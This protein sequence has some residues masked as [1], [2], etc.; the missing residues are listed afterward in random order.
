MY[1][2]ELTQP[3]KLTVDSVLIRVDSTSQAY[4]AYHDAKRIFKKA[5]M[6]LR[7]WN[8][9]S[10]EFLDQILES[11]CVCGDISKVF[12][13]GWNRVSDD[14]IFVSGINNIMPC[15]VITRHEVLH[16]VLQ[17]FDPLG[18][19]VPI[20][21]I[22][23]VFVQKLWTLNQLWD[24]PLSG[25]L[26]ESWNHIVH[27]FTQISLVKIPRFIGALCKTAV[28]QLLVF[29][30]ASIGAY[31]AAIYLRIEKETEIKYFQR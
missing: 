9:N 14:I 13:L 5:L 15:C 4:R 22:G 17:I 20:T 16:Y 28:Y 7:E 10:V 24:E 23:K 1:L 12:G 29:C 31:A 21:F 11:E 25:D 27:I 18:L 26:E 3:V 8:C 6:N 19:L 2:L 30:D